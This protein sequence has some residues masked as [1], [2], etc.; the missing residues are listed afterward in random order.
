MISFDTQIVP[1]NCFEFASSCF[2]F[3]SDFGFR[4]SNFENRDETNYEMPMMMPVR[5][6]SS[7]PITT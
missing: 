2:G 6:T 1:W 5:N 3:V 7:P 4:A